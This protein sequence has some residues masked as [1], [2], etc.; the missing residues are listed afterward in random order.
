MDWMEPGSQPKLKN[1]LAFLV[2]ISKEANLAHVVLATSDYFLA[3]WLS[4]SRCFHNLSSF[5][6]YIDNYH[7][8]NLFF[9][10]F[11]LLLQRD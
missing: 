8:K 4:G 2:A 10:V 9:R 5:M 6:H 3:N 11:T 1:L 7:V